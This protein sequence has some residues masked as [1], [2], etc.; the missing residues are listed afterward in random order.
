M[1]R[2]AL[3]L[4]AAAALSACT[5]APRYER[6]ALPVAQA[7]PQGSAPPAGPSAADLPWRQA[8]QDEKLQG[9]VELAL[10]QNRDLRVAVANIERARALYRVQR[11]ELFP[12]ID[13][14]GAETRIHTPRNLTGVGQSVDTEQYSASVGFA[15]YELDLFGRVRSLNAAAL[16]SYFS[17]VEN[18][19]AAQISLIAEVAADYAALAADQDVLAVIQETLNSREEGS[20]L[21]RSRFEAGASS[22]L[23]L[24]QAETLTEQARSDAAAAAARVAQDRN[25]LELVV[26]APLP[27]A[28]LPQ[29]GLKDIR[30]AA[31]LPPGLPSDVLVRR[32][33]VLA[34][35]RTLRARNAD[36]GA[37]RAAFLPRISLTG[38][39]GT[40]SPD[41][42]G[43]FQAGTRA[44][45]FTP[46]VSLPL[47]SGGA[48]LAN[49]S[50]AKAD[51]RIAVAQYEKAIQTAF[52]EVA[53]ALA[54][55][56][57]IRDRVAAQGRLLL[58]AAEAQR[59]VQARYDRGVDSY[60]ALLDAQRTLYAARQSLIGAQLTDALNRIDLYKSVGGGADPEPAPAP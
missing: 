9:L 10:Q 43:L 38:S 59:L 34:A 37:A 49:L 56:A 44:W 20:R 1:L 12:A 11:A 13:A 30:L 15:A 26:G 6:P 31:D 50:V 52:R 55:H 18:R 46:Q 7:W 54:V 57:T 25:A 2:R 16:Q 36:I 27:A 21:I 14:T 29:G 39:L 51:R 4:V 28:L 23:D 3:L 60:L 48:N 47:F 41:L 53:D 22:G 5:L 19:R 45:S 8:F 32:P 33:D 58:Q 17:V 35:E 42:D 24:S 40:A